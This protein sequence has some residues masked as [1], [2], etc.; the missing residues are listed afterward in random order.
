MSK[1][2]L[3]VIQDALKGDA[4]AFRCITEL[5]P[6][7]GEAQKVFPPTYEGGTY[8]TEGAEYEQV[9]EDEWEVRKYRRVLLDSVQSQANRLEEVLLR[10]VRLMT[11]SLASATE[12]TISRLQI[13]RG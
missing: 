8:A 5:K 11:L 12:T 3:K 1:L 7:G 6:A 10:Y 13:F 2:T 4:A 9:G